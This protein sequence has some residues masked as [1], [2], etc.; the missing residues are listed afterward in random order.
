MTA[1]TFRHT[2][3]I[4]SWARRSPSACGSCAGRG[5]AGSADPSR[6]GAVLDQVPVRLHRRLGLLRQRSTP[7]IPGFLSPLAWAFTGTAFQKAI[8]WSIFLELTGLGCGWGPMNGASSRCSAASA[9][10]CGRARPSCRPSRASRIG[11]IQRTWLDV[12]L[13]AANQL[14]LLR[15]LVAPRSR[16]SCS[17]RASSDPADGPPDK[18][19]FLAARAEHYYVALVVHR[20][21]ARRT[22]S[23]SRSARSSGASSGSGPR[24]PSSTTTSRP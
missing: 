13:Y 14:F 22:A 20:G 9:T 15:A 12:A 4:E 17:R 19:L 11:G 10:S 5:R 2:T 1:P 23:G 18:T 16:P 7:A 24:P 3:P 21:R 6:D 8:V